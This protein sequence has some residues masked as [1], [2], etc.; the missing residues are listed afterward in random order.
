M[1]PY[2]SSVCIIANSFL[3]SV[4]TLSYRAR[5]AVSQISSD[6]SFLHA[7]A[8]AGRPFDVLSLENITAAKC[9]QKNKSERGMLGFRPSAKQQSIFEF[10]LLSTFVDLRQ[11]RRDFLRNILFSTSDH[12]F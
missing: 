4:D 6:S 1:T 7:K 9:S 12:P 5:P 10:S 2:A 11:V 3:R 8:P